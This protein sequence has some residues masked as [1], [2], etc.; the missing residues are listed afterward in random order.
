MKRMRFFIIQTFRNYLL[1][2]EVICENFQT[3][4]ITGKDESFPKG[5]L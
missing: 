2:M 4:V 5:L 3:L 1:E